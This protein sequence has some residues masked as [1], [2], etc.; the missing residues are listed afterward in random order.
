MPCISTSAT[1]LAL[2]RLL[3]GE[4]QGEDTLQ[5]AAGQLPPLIKQACQA[6]KKQPKRAV[7]DA[8]A[9]LQSDLNA[10]QLAAIQLASQRTLTLWQGPPGSGKTHTL[11]CCLTALSSL[12]HGVGARILACAGSNIAVDNLVE[13]LLTK[14]VRVV[15]VGQPARISASLQKS[16]LDALAAKHPL[17]ATFHP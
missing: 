5:A 13:A 11:A 12:T 15:R 14:G 2:Y 3:H 17:G 1:V 6:L 7:K 16:S 10:S 8:C 9:A 4:Q